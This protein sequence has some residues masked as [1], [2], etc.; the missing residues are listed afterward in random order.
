MI[1]DSRLT[2]L[3]KRVADDQPDAMALL[4]DA[5][6]A[7]VYGLALR[8][9]RAADEAEE[10]VSDVYVQVWRQAARFEVQRGS[11]LGWILMITRSRALDRIRRRDRATPTESP[12]ERAELDGEAPLGADELL[13]AVESG[14]ALHEALRALSDVQREMIDLAFFEGLT[15]QEIAA[16]TRTPL[17]TVKSHV[18]R[19]LQALAAALGTEDEED[20]R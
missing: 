6:A 7:R 14:S 10:V 4:Y 13:A 18:R 16:R 5:T 11:P 8:I 2:D 12:P 17:G 15:H 3:L 19:G 20:D 1:D 9:T